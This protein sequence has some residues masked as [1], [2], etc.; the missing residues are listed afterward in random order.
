MELNEIEAMLA[1][2][3]EVPEAPENESFVKKFGKKI[4][5]AAVAV[6]GVL[7][8]TAMAKSR[9]KDRQQEFWFPETTEITETD[10]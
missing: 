3:P 8:V 5:V 4:V 1:E 2:M 9:S 6:G 10:I 7:A